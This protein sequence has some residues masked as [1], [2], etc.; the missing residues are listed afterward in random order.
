M[1]YGAWQ[2]A[3]NVISLTFMADLTAVVITV[4]SVA[5]CTAAGAVLAPCR[6]PCLSATNAGDAVLSKGAS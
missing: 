2:D 6:R 1:L 5:L 3:C 4:L